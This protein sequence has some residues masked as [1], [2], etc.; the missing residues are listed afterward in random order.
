MRTYI[1]F[2]SVGCGPLLDNSLLEITSSSFKATS[3]NPGIPVL[4]KSAWDPT[5]LNQ[6]QHLTVDLGECFHQIVYLKLAS[7]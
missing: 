1:F 4:S 3:G 5:I 2:V 7:S 6:P